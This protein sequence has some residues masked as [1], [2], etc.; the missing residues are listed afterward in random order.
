MQVNAAELPLSTGKT[1]RLLDIPGHPRLRD[2]FRAELANA[3]AIAFVVDAS[4][5]SRSASA[6]AE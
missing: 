1:L 4:T 5:V 6:V 3:R 2:Q